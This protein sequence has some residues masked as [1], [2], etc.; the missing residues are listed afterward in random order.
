MVWS[1][2]K[3]LIVLTAVVAEGSRDWG[4]TW[5]IHTLLLGAQSVMKNVHGALLYPR[6]NNLPSQ[7]Y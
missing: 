4:N 5:Q 2:A 3:D 7:L 6:Q 1:E